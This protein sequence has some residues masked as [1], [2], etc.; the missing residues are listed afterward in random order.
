MQPSCATMLPAPS[1]RWSKPMLVVLTER[2]FAWTTF[3]LVLLILSLRLCAVFLYS[4][5]ALLGLLIVT[6]LC[7]L[8]LAMAML[9]T[10]ARLWAHQ[11]RTAIWP[12]STDRWR[13][14]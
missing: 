6:G 9:R 3:F 1:M 14:S 12:R 5:I 7:L 10:W 11:A 4:L 13:H 2:L 8:P